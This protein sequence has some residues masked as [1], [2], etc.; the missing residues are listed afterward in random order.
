[1]YV[2]HPAKRVL[3]AILEEKNFHGFMATVAESQEI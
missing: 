1:M 3:P 2:E